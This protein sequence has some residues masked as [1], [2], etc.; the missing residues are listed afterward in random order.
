MYERDKQYLI[1]Y[2][3]WLGSTCDASGAGDDGERAMTN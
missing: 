1:D 3:K 2:V